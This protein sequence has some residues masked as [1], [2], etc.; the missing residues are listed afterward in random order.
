MH[1]ARAIRL[2]VEPKIDQ[3]RLNI[4]KESNTYMN[5]NYDQA[6]ISVSLTKLSISNK[7]L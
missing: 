3:N 5:R 4:T 1:F 6:T 2:K 7:H